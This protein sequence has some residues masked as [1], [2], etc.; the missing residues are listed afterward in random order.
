MA[1]WSPSAIS[2]GSRDGPSWQAR[3]IAQ[4]YSLTPGRLSIRGRA[5]G[6]AEW[7]EEQ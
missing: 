5:S 2:I 7:K 4:R 1:G 6:Q 3:V